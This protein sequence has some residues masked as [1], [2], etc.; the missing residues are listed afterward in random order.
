MFSDEL[1]GLLPYVLKSWQVIAVTIAFV[2]CVSFANY[3]ARLYHRPRSVS[4]SR[5]KKAKT[6]KAP[7]V[8]KPVEKDDSD[9]IGPKK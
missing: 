2:L 9:D 5:A 6:Q 1:M 7:S 8:E 4:K 3:V